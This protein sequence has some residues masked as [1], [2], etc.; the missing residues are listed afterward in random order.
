L[1]AHALFFLVASV[2]GVV[3]TYAAIGP[4]FN[5]V[6]GYLAPFGMSGGCGVIWYDP[7]YREHVGSAL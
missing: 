4:L 2:R 1:D 3:P 6:Y 5:E 7:E